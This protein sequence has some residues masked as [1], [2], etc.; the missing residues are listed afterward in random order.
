[1]ETLKK[2]DAK[3]QDKSVFGGMTDDEIVMNQGKF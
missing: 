3:M 1:M 2:N